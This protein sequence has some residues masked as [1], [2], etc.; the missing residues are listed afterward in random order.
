M[1][2]DQHPKNWK[3][4]WNTQDVSKECFHNIFEQIIQSF[5]C[6]F[7]TGATTVFLV[8]KF[9]MDQ[10]DA[11]KIFLSSTPEVSHQISQDVPQFSGTFE[12]FQVFQFPKHIPT[13]SKTRHK[14]GK[15]ITKHWETG[16]LNYWS[17]AHECC[18]RLTHNYDR[19]SIFIR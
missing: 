6:S 7:L 9:E 13:C 4:P 18:M 11:L 15:V 17:M 3:T 2:C 1:W 10:N 8:W 5:P 19:T 16:S 14:R 12:T